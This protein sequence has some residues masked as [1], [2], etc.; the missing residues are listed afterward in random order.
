[1]LKWKPELIINGLKIMCMMMELLV[2][3]DSVS[4][5]PF[6]L[7]K[8]PE[9][10][11]LTATTS[12]SHHYF[13]TEVNLNY[14]GPIPDGSFY[15][16][17]E[18]SEEERREFLAWYESQKSLPF[19]NR[20]VLETYCQD[21]VTVLRQACRVFRREFMHIGN[22]D[23]FV[24]AI[25]ITS[26]CN[27]VLRELFPKPDRIGLFLTGRYTANSKYRRKAMMKLLHMEQ[28]D[29][30]RTMHNRNRRD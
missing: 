2:F 6:S 13:N 15:G 23:I 14:V 7:R 11:G 29:G 21:D 25:T 12:R 16:A 4:I 24:E 22:I 8:L 9:A 10:F 1:V 19:D 5:L 18:M 20:H 17:N 28:T 27:K 3:L 26:A 30:V